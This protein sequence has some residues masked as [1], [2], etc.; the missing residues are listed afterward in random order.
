[1]ALWEFRKKGGFWREVQGVR[2]GQAAAAH[3]SPGCNSPGDPQ[4][5]EDECLW[6]KKRGRERHGHATRRERKCWVL[7]L[8]GF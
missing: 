1:M 5:L 4:S 3:Y 7:F 8:E 2:P 6:G